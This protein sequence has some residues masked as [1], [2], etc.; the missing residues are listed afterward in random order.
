VGDLDGSGSL[1][2]V[3]FCAEHP[4]QARLA[5]FRG[6][7]RG[8][9]LPLAWIDL[10]ED[11]ADGLL[12]TR[13]QLLAEDLDGDGRAEVVFASGGLVTVFRIDPR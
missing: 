7:G 13:G 4:R 3:C 6:D 11:F 12:A 2:L 8:G 10:V 9:F 1:D 5:V